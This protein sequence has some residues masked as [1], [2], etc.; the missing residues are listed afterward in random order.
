MSVERLCIILYSP[1][2]DVPLPQTSPV[3][4]TTTLYSVFSLRK[5]CQGLDKDTDKD[6]GDGVVNHTR[7]RKPHTPFDLDLDCSP[8]TLMNMLG[9]IPLHS[10]AAETSRCLSTLQQIT[11][12]AQEAKKREENGREG[13]GKTKRYKIWER[14]R[15]EEERM[16]Q[17]W[18]W[19]IHNIPK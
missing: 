19:I 4:N 13:L 9:I 15:R 16:K 6:S 11:A 7:T 14:G 8:L 10:S 17:R 18:A 5:W 3:W 2:H 1:A 12:G